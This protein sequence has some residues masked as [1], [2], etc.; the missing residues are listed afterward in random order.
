MCYLHLNPQHVPLFLTTT[1]I[2]LGFV[3]VMALLPKY[4]KRLVKGILAYHARGKELEG[5]LYRYQK[6][7][8]IL[9][10]IC[11]LTLPALWQYRLVP[12]QYIPFVFLTGFS[13]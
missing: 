4:K 13:L 10:F 1:I 8:F 11:T 12:I 7:A 6:L 9:I 3:A 5:W 2:G